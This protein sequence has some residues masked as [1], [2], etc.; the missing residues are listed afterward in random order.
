[1]L[2]LFD[3]LKL[4]TVAALLVLANCQEE[5]T[6]EEK[7]AEKKEEGFFAGLL[8]SFAL[9]F[10]SEIGDRTFIMVTIY[11]SRFNMCVLLLVSSVGMILMHTLT[12]LMGSVLLLFMPKIGAQIICVILFFT[13]GTWSIISVV[14]HEFS[15][16]VIKFLK[17]AFI[18]V[19]CC[20][21]K[22]N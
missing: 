3:L 12:T 8:Q 19:C 14:C 15:K 11:A 5:A 2:K 16:K 4:V 22:K 10:V 6:T 13:L 21:C 1:M 18:K 7:D 17:K 9:V 20:C